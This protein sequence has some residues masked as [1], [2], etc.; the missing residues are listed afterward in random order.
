MPE[1]QRAKVVQLG[2]RESVRR[3]QHLPE[4]RELQHLGY[5]TDAR[6][7]RLCVASPA[8]TYTFGF[9]EHLRKLTRLPA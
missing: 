1:Q 5:R 9:R 8:V 6:H 2:E 7:P 4:R 3:V